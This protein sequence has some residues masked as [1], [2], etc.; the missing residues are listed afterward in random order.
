MKNF[1]SIMW[2]LA[3]LAATAAVHAFLSFR[4]DVDRALVQRAALLDARPESVAQTMR[5][6]S[7]LFISFLTTAN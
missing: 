6:I 3:V 2:L 7:L 5:S 1:R 4:G